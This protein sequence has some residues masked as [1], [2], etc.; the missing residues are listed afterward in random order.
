MVLPARA[1]VVRPWLKVAV[2]ARRPE[3]STAQVRLG[4]WT[5]TGQQVAGLLAAAVGHPVVRGTTGLPVVASTHLLVVPS[6]DRAA[7][8]RVL[9]DPTPG[10]VR[11]CPSPRRRRAVIAAVVE[12][13]RAV[14]GPVAAVAVPKVAAGLVAEAARTV[15]AVQ[16]VAAI[17]ILVAQSAVSWATRVTE[18]TLA[19]QARPETLEQRAATGACRHRIVEAAG[20]LQVAPARDVGRAAAAVAVRGVAAVAEPGG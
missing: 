12:A 13:R 10:W 16:S 8:S 5:L 4:H 20:T 9:V 2:A 11:R 1:P 15:V 7:P 6:S 14:V 17:E 18:V 19:K 3:V